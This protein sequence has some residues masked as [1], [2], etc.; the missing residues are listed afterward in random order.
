[1]DY[2]EGVLQVGEHQL[3]YVEA[4]DGEALVWLHGGFG[5]YPSAGTDLL[6]ERFRLV[7]LELPGFGSSLQLDGA[8]T[9]DELSEQVAEAIQALGLSTYLLHGTS[10]GG[11]VALH[12]ALN[13]PDRVTRL[14]L[15]SPAAFRPPGWTPPDIDTIRRGL[16]RHPERARRAQIDPEVIQ[17]Q[18]DFTN[19]LAL[20]LD[21]EAL[22]G[23][24]RDLNVPTLVMF[25]DAD[26]LTP[27]EL[28][29]MYCDHAP[30]CTLV[31]IHDAAHV[32]SSDQPED[33][34]AS[35]REFAI[36]AR[37]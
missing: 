23:R 13:H 18:R 4:G 21:R 9:F 25:G 32:I 31:V 29:P 22:G 19:R 37:A 20:T 36:Q 16:F 34:A 28:A 26:T 3:R 24:L 2:T 33:Y 6:A 30:D 15:E 10:F 35:V 17:T 5:L 7:A 1:M 11:A 14:I 12:V 27:V 8:R